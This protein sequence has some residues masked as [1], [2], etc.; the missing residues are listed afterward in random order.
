MEDIKVN[1]LEAWFNSKFVND[2]TTSGLPFKIKKANMEDLIMANQIPLKIVESL[3]QPDDPVEEARQTEE[4]K[5]TKLLQTYAESEALYDALLIALLIEPKLGPRDLANGIIS[6]G[7]LSY[8][9]KEEMCNAAQ[10]GVGLLSTF[11]QEPEIN[12]VDAPD[13]ADIQLSSE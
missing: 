8:T 7:D 6:L 2:V 9:D 4:D 12:V 3:T 10:R 11:R 5:R 13:G 1:P